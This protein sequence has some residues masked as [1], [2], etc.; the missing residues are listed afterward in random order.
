MIPDHN[1][2]ES[3]DEVDCDDCGDNKDDV[4]FIV[5]TKQNRNNN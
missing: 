3:A 1:G 4:T 2:I 5:D